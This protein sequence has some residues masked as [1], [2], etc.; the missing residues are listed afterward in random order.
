MRAWIKQK[1]VMIGGGVLVAVLAWA[2]GSRLLHDDGGSQSRGGR[3][4]GG[5]VPVE[6]VPVEQGTL[7]L[8]RTLSG[9][10][11]PEARLTL[12]PKVSGRL[13]RL[14]VDVSDTV[15]R[16]EIVAVLE[17]D[18]FRQ[19]VAEANARLAVAEANRS[20]ARSRLEIARRE[21]DRVQTL[22]ERGI[23]SESDL[24]TARAE[25]LAAEAGVDVAE[26]GYKRD[27]AARA[28]AEIRLG[29]TEIRAEWDR[30]DDARIIAERF[31]DE[32]DTVAANTPLFSI[33]ELDPILAVIQVTEKDYPRVS[34][35]QSAEVVADAFPG[36]PFTGVVTRI[37]PVFRES[38][39]QARIEVSIPNPDYL[40]KPGMFARCTLELDRVE[41]AV[42]V[43]V[44]AVTERNGETGV[45]RILDDSGTARWEPVQTGLEDGGFVQ[46]VDAAFAGRVVTLGQQMLEDGSAVRIPGSSED[47]PEAA[48]SP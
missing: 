14:P 15:K 3:S 37:A 24:D 48:D 8:H 44:E 28:A 4:P 17:D 23:A 29:Y 20:E 32:G 33:V 35:S 34:L 7:I 5:A 38:S 18:E 46:L 22:Q 12:A 36:R 2:I 41:E 19:A 30:G 6:A 39:R 47:V 45:F 27:Q 13:M 1:P 43:P 42:F 10:L 40:L 9:T 31:V 26:A 21:W 11:E 16:G 25:F